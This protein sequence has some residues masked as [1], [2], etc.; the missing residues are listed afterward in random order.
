[1]LTIKVFF[2]NILLN[3]FII[4]IPKGLNVCDRCGSIGIIPSSSNKFVAP[5]IMEKVKSSLAISQE[6]TPKRASSEPFV[7]VSAQFDKILINF[8]LLKLNYL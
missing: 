7:S 8:I 5:Q 6:K 3:V 4:F 1:M 2:F